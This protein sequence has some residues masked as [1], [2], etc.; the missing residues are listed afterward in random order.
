MKFEDLTP[1]ATEVLIAAAERQRRWLRRGCWIGCGLALVAI[2]A[3]MS[4]PLF[5]RWQLRRQGWE[6]ETMSRRGLP[7]WAPRWADPWFGRVDSAQLKHAS[8]RTS[9]VD[10]LRQFPE[11]D[12]VFLEATVV[13]D[14][15]LEKVSQLPNLLFVSFDSVRLESSG[16]RHLLTTPKLDALNFH[17]MVLDDTALEYLAACHHLTGLRLT[18]VTDDNVRYLARIPSLKG[19]EIQD[20]RLTDQGAKR[21]ADRCLGLETLVVYSGSFSDA[22][23][24]EVARLPKLDR[25]DV[26]GVA[27]TDDGILKLKTCATLKTVYF[28][29]TKVTPA[30]VSEFKKH[31]PS[32]DVGVE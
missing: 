21:L 11:I 23:V 29:K 31:R 24:A 1:D 4:F 5:A 26:A 17:N 16:L 14:A 6:L 32:V 27:I 8:L 18:G 3:E 10:L 2:V 25:L 19:L 13:T 28:R 30:G 15:A 12:L 20:C 9:D 7:D 22:A